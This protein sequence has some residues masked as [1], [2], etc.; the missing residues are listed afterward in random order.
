MRYLLLFFFFPFPGFSQLSDEQEAQIDSLKEV[1][2]TANHDT[3]IISAWQAWDNIIWISDPELDF[4]LNE[5]IEELCN[6][7]LNDIVSKKERQFYLKSLSSA[8]NVIGLI[9]HGQG[10][11][12]SAMDYHNQSLTINKE[13]GDKGRIAKSLNNIGM[14]FEAQGDYASAID[15]YTHS[16]SMLEEIGDQTGVAAALNN[17]GIIYNNQGDHS[18]AIDYHT[19]S[20]AINK[21]IG[22][23]KR[24]A[25]SLNNIGI[26][27]M[28]QG[29]NDMAMDYHTRSLTIKQEIGDKHG[30]AASFNNIG[31]IYEKQGDFSRAINYYRSSL[32]IYEEIG[33]KHGITKSL[34]NIGFF[35]I[36][37]GK[38][39][40]DPSQRETLFRKAISYGNR[41]LLIAQ[42]IGHTVRTKDAANVLYKSNKAIGE[43]Q[44]ALKMHELYITMRDSILSEENHKEIIR[45]QYKY[46]YEKQALADSVTHAKES[47][48]KDVM[49]EKKQAQLKS[50]KTQRYAL[51]GG[52]GL[53]GCLAFVLLRGFQ[54][55]KKD[56]VVISL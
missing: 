8:L 18:S 47:Q 12:A 20:L 53:V 28:E 3:I 45:Q 30:I 9:H 50:E 56:N 52:L 40:T 46:Q 36:N 4:D 55:K 16:L 5:K 29:D 1:I 11:Y 31:S 41:A 39:T 7:N 22:D 2:E 25:A 27:Y 23:Q 44:K 54:R 10:N 48:I 15:Y 6:D 34:N 38:S 17:I 19:Q 33:D 49:L 21:E 51:Y 43:N 37:Q 14:I 24:I 42:E 32:D 13:I 35:Y 26:I